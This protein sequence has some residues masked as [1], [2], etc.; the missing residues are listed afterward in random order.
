VANISGPGTITFSDDSAV[1]NMVGK[2]SATQGSAG[3]SLA[4]NADERLRA[5]I[6]QAG[7]LTLWRSGD[8]ARA[9]RYTSRDDDRTAL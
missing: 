9:I 6:A 5:G 3:R 1:W 7:R 4:A 2:C 8:P